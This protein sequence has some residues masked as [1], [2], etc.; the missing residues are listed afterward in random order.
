LIGESNPH[1]LCRQLHRRRNVATDLPKKKT[2][3]LNRDRKVAIAFPN[4]VAARIRDGLEELFT[5]R[6]LGLTGRLAATLT[7]IN[8]CESMI[9]IAR[10]TTK[11]VKRWPDGQGSSGRWPRECSALRAVRIRT[12]GPRALARTGSAVL[13]SR[14]MCSSDSS[15]L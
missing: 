1:A 4:P 15:D 7:T 12:P 14:A 10:D 13:P 3:A 9:S 8:L 5:D 11:N 2:T 6:R